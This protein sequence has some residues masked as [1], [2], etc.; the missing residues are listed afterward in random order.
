MSDRHSE[1]CVN[2]LLFV[3][4]PGIG[5]SNQSQGWCLIFRSVAR[6]LALPPLGVEPTQRWQPVI[7]SSLLTQ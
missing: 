7:N 1:S 3:M 6:P 5:L 4:M 2:L